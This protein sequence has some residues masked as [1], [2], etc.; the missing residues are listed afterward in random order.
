[1]WQHGSPRLLASEAGVG[2]G[3]RATH[4][5]SLGARLY[6]Q[7]EPACNHGRGATWQHDTPPRREAELELT[8]RGGGNGAH[9]SGW[10]KCSSP[11][12]GRR[13][14]GGCHR[15]ESSESTGAH[16]SMRQNHHGTMETEPCDNTVAYFL[17]RRSRGSLSVPSRPDT[18]TYKLQV[19]TSSR[20]CIHTLPHVI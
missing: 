9:L 6:G 13:S 17:K 2:H 10:Q 4:L 3:C 20:V 1:M 5:G 15:S 12:S 18:P 11:I 14:Q 8:S 16:I 19:N 7:V